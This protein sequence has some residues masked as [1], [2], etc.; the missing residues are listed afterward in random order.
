MK[1]YLLT[2]WAGTL[3][4]SLT[5]AVQMPGSVESLPMVQPVEYQENFKTS[6][7]PANNNA[8]DNLFPKA[9]ELDWLRFSFLLDLEHYCNTQRDEEKTTPDLQ[10]LQPSRPYQ[11]D[12][13]FSVEKGNVYIVIISVDQG[14]IRKIKVANSIPEMFLSVTDNNV[15]I[16]ETNTLIRTLSLAQRSLQTPDTNATCLFEVWLNDNPLTIEQWLELFKKQRQPH[17]P[18]AFSE[19][20]IKGRAFPVLPPEFKSV[21]SNVCE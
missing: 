9:S 5:H 2:A 11:P 21:C 17:F 16:P 12:V 4:S 13:F 10:I 8:S 19:K 20:V 1:G 14:V 6:W 7:P 3:L 15:L 18:L